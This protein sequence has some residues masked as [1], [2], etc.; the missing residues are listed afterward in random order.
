MPSDVTD[1]TLD[2]PPQDD[3]VARTGESARR[4]YSEILHFAEELR[5]YNGY[6]DTEGLNTRLRIANAFKS[7]ANRF[8]YDLLKSTSDAS[9]ASGIVV[10]DLD[11]LAASAEPP[12]ESALSEARAYLLERI[13]RESRKSPR[14]RTAVRLIP[15]A[16]IAVA[17]VVYFSVRFLSLI[18]LGAPIG[19]R[20][21]L[22]QRAAAYEKMY[23]YEPASGFTPRQIAKNIL[24]WPVEPTEE[25]IVAG[26]ELFALSAE[27]FGSLAERG[28]ICLDPV[29]YAAGVAPE[30]QVRLVHEVALYLQDDASQ[31]AAPPAATIA[32][33][34]KRAFPCR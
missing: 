6:L 33:P 10:A 12:S 34:I 15:L 28:E 5:F 2:Q 17:L 29:R 24:L 11:A 20:E 21:G 3:A 22:R 27:T 7:S 23:N 19:S 13:A 26:R 30:E 18:E 32:I 25:E 1:T 16:L 4:D 14:L 9:D 8:V 31:W